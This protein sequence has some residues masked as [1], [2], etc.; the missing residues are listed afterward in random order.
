MVVAAQA[1]S[2]RP[3]KLFASPWSPPAWMKAPRR[4]KDPMTGAWTGEYV[5]SMTLSHEPN[6]LRDDDETKRSWALYFSKFLSAYRA[7]GV[8]LWAVTV[9]NEPEFSAP[10][11][12]CRYNASF[13][14]HFV[15]DYLGPRL[16]Q[17]H[18]AVKIFAFDH[19]KDHV[20]SWARTL[21]ADASV[22]KW[23]AGIA[24]HWYV[25][26]STHTR[27]RSGGEAGG[28]KEEDAAEIAPSET[29]RK[30]RTP[31]PSLLSFQGTRAG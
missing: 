1:A 29:I 24:F 19:N 11:E 14:G 13:M 22:A 23:F 9:Q 7:Y 25:H 27:A 28:G 10:W 18:P 31:R 16:K 8:E 21:Y 5:Q 12:A 2:P 3:L 20:F 26:V 6:G 30:N 4:V 15:A 17:D